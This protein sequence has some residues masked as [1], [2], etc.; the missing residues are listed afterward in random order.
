MNKKLLTVLGVIIA[1]GAII[2]IVSLKNKPEPAP[3][4]TVAK[5]SVTSAGPAQ[6]VANVASTEDK[7][8]T[9][10]AEA[11][12]KGVGV[13]INLLRKASDSPLSYSLVRQIALNS[14]NDGQESW[15]PAANEK[16]GDM[17]VEVTCSTDYGFVKG[18][19]TG[20]PTKVQ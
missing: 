2:W 14:E 11:Y 1:I 18:C 15:T 8:I 6:N 3:A 4:D 5:V 10:S 9:W 12:P 13:N 7:V 17:Y 19:I 20:A 16:S